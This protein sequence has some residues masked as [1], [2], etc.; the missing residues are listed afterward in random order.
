MERKKHLK[1]SVDSA[2]KTK[3]TMKLISLYEAAHIFLSDVYLA[4]F[5]DQSEK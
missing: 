2:N 1:V 5:P 4:G 3:L